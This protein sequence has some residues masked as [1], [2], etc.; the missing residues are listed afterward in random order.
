MPSQ[1]KYRE[2]TSTSNTTDFQARRLNIKT[3]IDGQNQYVHTLNGTVVA[4]G[5]AVIAIY[6]N[7]KIPTGRLLF[8]NPPPYMGKDKI[9]AHGP[10]I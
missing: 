7:Y 2:V 9:T 3:K 8:P 6:E 10:Q 4:T 5:R 1:D